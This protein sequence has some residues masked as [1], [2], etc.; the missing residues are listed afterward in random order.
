MGFFDTMGNTAVQLWL[1]QSTVVFFIAA[2]ITLLAIGISLIMNSAGTLRF[3]GGMNRW[4]SMRRATKSLEIPHDTRRAVQKYRYWFAAVFVAGGILAVS[5]LLT[6][7]DVRAV[8]RVFGLEFFK[9]AFAEWI[10]DSARW[11]L[12]AGNLIGIVVGLLLAFSP[13][14]VVK[15][16]A[17]GSQWYSERQATRGADSLNLKLDVW[18]A[19]NPRV[20]GGGIV[21]FALALIGAFG[22]IVPR[23]W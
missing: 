22:L 9:P 16:E 19:A 18:V 23:L 12:V 4:M 20:A 8:V 3:F 17:R 10:V 1:A 13:Q 14:T 15:L 21:V 2:G 7:F 11:V 6:Q 5:G